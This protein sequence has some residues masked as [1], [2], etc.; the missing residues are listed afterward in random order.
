MAAAVGLKRK[1]GRIHGRAN[2]L[3]RK[4]WPHMSLSQKSLLPFLQQSGATTGVTISEGTATY[5]YERPC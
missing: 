4:K 1:K 5:D 2:G 3:K